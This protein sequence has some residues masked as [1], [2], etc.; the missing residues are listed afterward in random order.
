LCI[1]AGLIYNVCV[2]RIG[3]LDVITSHEVM[4]NV[5]FIPL[6]L[7]G[8]PLVPQ[9]CCNLV[10]TVCDDLE[11]VTGCLRLYICALLALPICV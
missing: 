5:M 9:Q 8:M 7:L 4:L 10:D 2:M 6:S 3:T 11:V 1:I